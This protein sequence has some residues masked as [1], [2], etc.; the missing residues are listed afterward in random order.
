MKSQLSNLFVIKIIM[1]FPLLRVEVL[2]L[3]IVETRVNTIFVDGVCNSAS[4]KRIASPH[5]GRVFVCLKY[6]DM[7]A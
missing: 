1:W 4:R 6:V 5:S 3:E 2:R 7:S